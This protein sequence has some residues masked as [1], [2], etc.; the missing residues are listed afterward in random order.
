MSLMFIRVFAGF[1]SGMFLGIVLT[2]RYFMKPS[3]PDVSKTTT[4]KS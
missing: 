4:E 3:A 1:L 2:R